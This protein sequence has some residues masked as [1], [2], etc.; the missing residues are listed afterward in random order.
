MEKSDLN[1][2][3]NF[4]DVSGVPLIRV[5]ANQDY[6]QATPLQQSVRLKIGGRAALFKGTKVNVRC[7]VKKFDRLVS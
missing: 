7:P 6:V 4:P 1:K 5:A 3:L 2:S